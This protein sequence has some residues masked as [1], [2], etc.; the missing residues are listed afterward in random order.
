MTSELNLIKSNILTEAQN[1]GIN[2]T[3]KECYKKSIASV[4][5][6][7]YGKKEYGDTEFELIL[8]GNGKIQFPDMSEENTDARLFVGHVRANK[9]F[10]SE[11]SDF[12][13][14]LLFPIHEK[15]SIDTKFD[16]VLSGLNTS[17]SFMSRVVANSDC[18]INLQLYINSVEKEL[19]NNSI[20]DTNMAYAD[21]IKQYSKANT[22]GGRHVLTAFFITFIIEYVQVGPLSKN[23]IK[24]IKSIL[25]RLNKNY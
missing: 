8:T 24:I 13:E 9:E 3:V 22:K 2:T 23:K 6:Y 5:L 14:L 15:V 11:A 18:R 10:T 17:D 1:S 16:V 20:L 12:I 21:Y 4:M 19:L 7:S 25:R